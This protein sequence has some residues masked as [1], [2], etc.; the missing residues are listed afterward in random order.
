MSSPSE[1]V[2][3]PAQDAWAATIKS[4]LARALRS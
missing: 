4:T 2:N 3:V 1:I